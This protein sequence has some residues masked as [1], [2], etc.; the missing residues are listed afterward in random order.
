MAVVTG[1]DTT[2]FAEPVDDDSALAGQPRRVTT[3]H[4]GMGVAPAGGS[5]G[6][7]PP[8]TWKMPGHG[9]ARWPKSSTWRGR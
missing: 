5:A 8:A 7:G 3:P 4:W 9:S 1:E 6:F 2:A